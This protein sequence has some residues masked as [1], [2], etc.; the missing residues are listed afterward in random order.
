[1]GKK[2][3]L[4]ILLLVTTFATLASSCCNEN[5][6]NCEPN[7][8]EKCFMNPPT[9]PNVNPAYRHAYME[10]YR[11]AV[12]IRN[13]YAPCF[14]PHG[15]AYMMDADVPHVPGTSE[16]QTYLYQRQLASIVA[17]VQPVGEDCNPFCASK[18]H[19]SFAWYAHS[20]PCQSRCEAYRFFQENPGMTSFN[21]QAAPSWVGGGEI[22]SKL[23]FNRPQYDGHKC[24]D[25]TKNELLIAFT[26][27]AI[28]P[29]AP[30]VCG[31]NSYN[32]ATIGVSPAAYINMDA[33]TNSGPA[34]HL[35][36]TVEYR[37]AASRISKC[38][39]TQ[40][41][42][43]VTPNNWT[44]KP[45]LAGVLT[46]PDKSKSRAFEMEKDEE[47]DRHNQQTFSYLDKKADQGGLAKEFRGTLEEF[48][49][50]VLKPSL[51]AGNNAAQPQS[52]KPV[53]G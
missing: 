41:C 27:S 53:R 14:K 25:C 10:I 50:K 12:G 13:L 31:G 23:C 45:T 28:I 44:K 16:S 26:N 52:V 47:L 8:W 19:N 22:L 29:S 4:I 32:C 21:Y 37:S 43:Y 39:H 49:E 5:G 36:N 48:N 11:A 30:S 20:W 24:M 3:H 1:L 17:M 2:K 33:W 6:C 9:G 40:C 18:F 35:P 34:Y 42:S 15:T 38:L 46:N 7:C 51:A